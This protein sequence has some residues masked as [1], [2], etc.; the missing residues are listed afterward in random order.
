MR[1]SKAKATNAATTPM[2]TASAEIGSTRELA[3]KSPRTSQVLR[4]VSLADAT[5]CSA[6]EGLTLTVAWRLPALA[7]SVRRRH[8]CFQG[9]GRWRAPGRVHSRRVRRCGA[10]PLARE[11]ARLAG[12]GRRERGSDRRGRGYDGRN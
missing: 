2:K 1:R 12:G 8:R 10:G 4:V 6:A 9:A 5:G 7:I 3:V 11:D